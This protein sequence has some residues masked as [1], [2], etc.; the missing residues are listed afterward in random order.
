VRWCACQ[1]HESWEHGIPCSGTDIVAS[2]QQAYLDHATSWQSFSLQPHSDLRLLPP[3]QASSDKSW[4]SLPVVCKLLQN[5]ASL[6]LG[7]M[8]CTVAAGQLGSC[9]RQ[10]HRSSWPCAQSAS[11]LWCGSGG[12]PGAWLWLCLCSDKHTQMLAAA[13]EGV[14]LN[15]MRTA[16]SYSSGQLRCSSWPLQGSH[17]GWRCRCCPPAPQLSPSMWQCLAL[18]PW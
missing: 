8:C 7:S 17:H 14:A 15:G 4:G 5:S 3:P 11:M 6:V 2:T 12:K 1:C 18:Q 13:V 9:S 10:P 16:A